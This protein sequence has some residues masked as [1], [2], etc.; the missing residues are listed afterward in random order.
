[1]SD[2]LVQDIITPERA[3]ARH[4]VHTVCDCNV[5][6]ALC[7]KDLSDRPPPFYDDGMPECVV[8]YDL[9]YSPCMRCGD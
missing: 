6:F 9:Y 7:G 4:F 1:M 2:T 8:C 3:E 5:D